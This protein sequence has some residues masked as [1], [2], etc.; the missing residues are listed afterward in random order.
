MHL[1]CSAPVIKSPNMS[2]QK[3]NEPLLRRHIFIVLRVLCRARTEFCTHSRINLYSTCNRN[4]IRPKQPLRFYSGSCAFP[5]DD[6][7]LSPRHACYFCHRRSSESLQIAGSF[8]R[9]CNYAPKHT[10]SAR[11]HGA[12]RCLNY[13]AC[14]FI[15]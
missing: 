3:Q 15:N 7:E 12:K 6:G 5:P 2:N 11:K 10:C 1:S 8:G 13:S 4:L 14:K 9:R